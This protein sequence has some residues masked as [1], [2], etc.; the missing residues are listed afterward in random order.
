MLPQ[1]AVHQPWASLSIRGLA[2]FDIAP[3]VIAERTLQRQ[4]KFCLR[5]KR[6]EA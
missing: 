5:T 6:R 4:E 3:D 1:Y 2:F